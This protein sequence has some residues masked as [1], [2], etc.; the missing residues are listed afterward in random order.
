MEH[1]S[2]GE[3]Q[4]MTELK[5]LRVMLPRTCEHC[6]GLMMLDADDPGHS[7]CGECCRS[8]FTVDDPVA[9]SREK[10]NEGHL[11]GHRG[12]TARST[13]G[14]DVGLPQVSINPAIR[15]FR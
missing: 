9:L 4:A 5:L 12:L 6:N 2:D 10:D 14:R 3:D 8:T 13:K 11:H 1:H 15:G 7:K